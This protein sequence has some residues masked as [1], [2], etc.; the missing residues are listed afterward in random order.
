MSLTALWVFIYAL[1][2]EQFLV[3]HKQAKVIFGPGELGQ[4]EDP[5]HT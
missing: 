4:M 1:M 5:A 3:S 2:K